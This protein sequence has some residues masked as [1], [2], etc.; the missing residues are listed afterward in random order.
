MVHLLPYERYDAYQKTVK[1]LSEMANCLADHNLCQNFE[2]ALQEQDENVDLPEQVH[3][4][5]PH[6]D[7]SLEDLEGADHLQLVTGDA[8]TILHQHC[9][10]LDVHDA[11]LHNEHV[12]HNA[13]HLQHATGGQQQEGPDLG[14]ENIRKK[15]LTKKKCPPKKCPTKKCPW[16]RYHTSKES[17][18]ANN[19][20]RNLR[21]VERFGVPAAGL[22][23]I[24]RRNYKDMLANK[25][26]N[27]EET[28]EKKLKELTDDISERLSKEVFRDEGKEVIEHTRTLL[29]L[30]SLAVKIRKSSSVK[31]ALMEFG[32][33]FEALM[34]IPVEDLRD[35]PRDELKHQFKVFVSRL[36]EV[37]KE[38]SI[39][40]LKQLDSKIL[41]KQFF[42]PNKDLFVDIEMVLHAISVASVKLSCESILESFVSQYE[43]H[44]DEHRNVS[45]ETANEEF[46]IAR[47]GPNLAHADGVITEALDMYWEGKPWHFYRTSPLEKLV[48]PS[49]SSSTLKRFQA[50]RNPLPIM[51]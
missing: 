26:E 32:R 43:N 6:H 19:S 25:K 33:W 51:D 41:I 50:T 10:L 2:T 4:E 34:K 18:K 23:V 14:Q 49:G 9:H 37:T 7:P 15:A 44:F 3:V 24:T 27:V 40:E 46:L 16:S 12:G 31:A 45:E 30:P 21:V 11:D 13:Q 38:Y 17:L 1:R 20:I 48:H 36:E 47:N 28:T 29:D 8:D 39:E 5:V 35:V 42:D 22:Q